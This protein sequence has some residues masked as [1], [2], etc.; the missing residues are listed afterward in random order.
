MNDKRTETHACDSISRQAAIDAIKKRADKARDMVG[1]DHPFWEGL[2][3]A[4]DIVEQLPSVQPEIIRCRD[5]KYYRKYGYIN[6]KPEFLPKCTFCSIYV[7][8]DDFCSKAERRKKH[9]RFNQQKI[10]TQSIKTNHAE[11]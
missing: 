2:I 5:C 4:L 9:E 7:N 6:G 3:V 10:S 1:S 8:A 11:V